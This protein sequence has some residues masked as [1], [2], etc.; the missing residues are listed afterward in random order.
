[1]ARAEKILFLH[2]LIYLLDE[3]SNKFGRQPVLLCLYAGNIIRIDGAIRTLYK[4]LCFA[5]LMLVF[6]AYLQRVFGK[7]W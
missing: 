4:Y 5:N 3:R 7:I 1:M 2:F 6:R